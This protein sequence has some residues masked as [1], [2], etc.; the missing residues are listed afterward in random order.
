MSA[1]EHDAAT[2]G[3]RIRG[4][5]RAAAGEHLCSFHAAEDEQSRLASAFVSGALGAGDRL[6]YV[7]HDHEPA[8]I[9]RVLASGGLDVQRPILSGQL[10]VRDFDAVYGP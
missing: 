6:I 7:A 9:G 8:A 4:A 5:A 2:S 1:A 10:V 3:P